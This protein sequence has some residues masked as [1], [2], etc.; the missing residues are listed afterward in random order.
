MALSPGARFGPYEI[1]SLIG[2]GGM[3]EVYRALDSTLGREVA[4]KVLPETVARQPERLDR[5]AREARLL[6]SL[7][8]P[9]IAIVHGLDRSEEVCFLEMELV[10]GETL[11]E[12]IA[13]GPIEAVE[14]LN[15]FKQIAEALEAAHGQNIVHRDLKPENIMITPAGIV[16]VLDFGLAKVLTAEDS[17]PTADSATLASAPTLAGLVMGTA[18]YMSPE[19]A[20]G[21][22]VDRRTDIWAFGCLLYESMTGH[23]AFPG[24][25]A[26]DTIAVVLREEPDWARLAAVSP[27]KLLLLIRRCLQKNRHLRLHDIADARIEIDEALREAI[28]TASDIGLPKTGLHERVVTARALVVPAVAALIALALGAG[29]TRW[30]TGATSSVAPSL[31]RVMITLPPGQALEKGRFSPVVISP[32]GR[33]LAYAAAV[34][35]GQTHLYLR[36]LDELEARPIPASDGATA[37]F[38][39]SDGRWL[40]F[41]ADRSLKKVSMAGGV[42]LTIGETPPIWS[43]TWN[44]PTIVFAT[45]LASSGLWQVSADG[46]EP[47]QITSP[48]QGET[49][50]GYPQILPG[51]THVLFSVLR[52]N[53]WRLAVL[54]LKSREWRLLGNGRIVGEGARYLPTGHIVYAQSGG[55]V[56]TPFDSPDGDLNRPPMPLLEHLE[57][58]RFGGAYFAVAAEAGSLVYLPAGT[59]VTDRALLRVDRD[60]RAAP[61]VDARLGYEDPAFSPDGRRLAVTITSD[62]GSDIWIIDLDRGTRIRFTTG[63]SSAFPVWSLD[64]SRLAFQ[65]T[66]PGPWNL[67]WKPIDGSGE[68]QPLLH[69]STE[70]AT[71]WP[72]TAST[73]LPGTLPTLSG[74]NPQFPMSWAPDRSALAFHERKPNGERDIW[75]V[76]PEGDPTPFLMTPFDERS[77]RFSPDGKWLAYVSNE[78]GRDEVY[79]QPF[80]GPGRKWL[81]STDGGVDPIWSR[82]GRELFYRQGEQM[83]IVVIGSTADFSADRPRRLFE[84][85]FDAGVNGPNYDVSPD[86]K[87]FV[88]PRS[89]RGP[90]PGALHFV[91]NWFKE[92]T[93]RTPAER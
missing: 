43:A 1:I 60:G 33:L 29:V 51:G 70:P 39:S 31:A 14:A 61:L 92:V 88:M 93:S 28:G 65:T 90:A 9:N 46:G 32:D 20:R 76:A 25:T 34:G 63:G 57:T 84:I 30:L 52:E 54:T 10:R 36:A 50:H 23:R 47:V 89:E 77:P 81:I 11:G 18:G 16:K 56:A 8:H 49:Q 19:Q 85:R 79:V 17:A 91:L 58:S 4:I 2:A 26:S 87:W 5:F 86:G 22:P 21:D 82:D 83:M 62:A 78:S 69:A 35:G 71:S 59:A 3:G 41:Y 67:Y 38:F 24:R 74:A 72:T 68:A 37:P 44:G 7:S 6:A 75:V 55:L 12:R 13:R 40:A 53:G 66:A 27:A 64:G 73:L 80:P 15:I 42:P 45:T 48:K